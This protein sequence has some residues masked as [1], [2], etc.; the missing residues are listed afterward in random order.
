MIGLF[1]FWTVC[2]IRLS[3][4]LRGA[5]FKG[6]FVTDSLRGKSDPP[7]ASSDAVSA[8]TKSEAGGRWW[9]IIQLLGFIRL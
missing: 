6:K 5:T 9:G 8:V 2:A 7:A 3:H 1:V 4:A